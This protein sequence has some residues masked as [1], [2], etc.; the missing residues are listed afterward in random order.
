[1]VFPDGQRELPLALRLLRVQQQVF[2]VEPCA[3]HTGRMTGVL[4]RGVA[5]GLHGARIKV[6]ELAQ[7]PLGVALGVVGACTGEE[8]EGL[9]G[10]GFFRGF[11]ERA[12]D[13][14]LVL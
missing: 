14:R 6:D 7:A 10:F 12:R 1:M 5:F 4:G 9:D 13:L 2:R 8:D 3:D 11:E